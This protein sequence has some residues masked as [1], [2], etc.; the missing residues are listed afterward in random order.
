MDIF[1]N[2][3]QRTAAT[4]WTPS[5]AQE[6]LVGVEERMGSDGMIKTESVQRAFEVIQPLPTAERAL[7][8][9]TLLRALHDC[10]EL[11][12]ELPERLLELPAL[13]RSLSPETLYLLGVMLADM[14]YLKHFLAGGQPEPFIADEYLSTLPKVDN[15]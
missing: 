9:H 8:Q 4:C 5:T 3:S 10:R 13:L 11:T 14:R 2:A 7:L 15:G 12:N 1:P 6:T